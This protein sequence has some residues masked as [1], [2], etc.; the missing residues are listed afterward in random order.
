MYHN[1]IKTTYDKLT[2]SIRPNKEELKN[3]PLKPR[4]RQESPLSPLLFNTVLEALAMAIREE[5][6]VMG[7]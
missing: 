1:T 6:E 3:F 2:G 5:K 7:T 4:T